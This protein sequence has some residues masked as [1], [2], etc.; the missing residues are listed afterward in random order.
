MVH[1]NSSFGVMSLS[2]MALIAGVALL[3]CACNSQRSKK[4]EAPAE[5]TEA[6]APETEAEELPFIDVEVKP[7]FG[8]GDANEFA[9][10]F[11][12]N[13]TYPE[14]AKQEGIEG[15]VVVRFCVEK[16]GSMSDIEIVKGLSPELDAEVLRVM[17]S[18]TEKWTPGM[19]GGSPVRV[20]FMFPVVFKLN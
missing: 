7:T 3:V 8:G 19:Q 18:C 4:A 20:T 11:Y 17:D 16:D 15:R 14:S 13:V 2:L 10:W 9:K 5:N 12:E 1:K 6:V